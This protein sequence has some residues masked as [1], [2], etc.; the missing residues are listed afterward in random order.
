MNKPDYIICA[1]LHLVFTSNGVLALVKLAR[2][3]EKT[4]R[5]AFMCTYQ[6]V[7][8]VETAI[9]IDYDTYVPRNEAE[10]DFIGLIRRA[11][12]E[13][14][15]TLLKDFSQRHVDE[16]IIVYPEALLCNP[17]NGKRVVRY[18]LNRDGIVSG[19]KVNRP[20]RFHPCSLA[21]HASQS[22]SRLLFRSAQSAVS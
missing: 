18:F 12:S 3:I 14:G 16:C 21:G 2:S 8:G 11:T 1:P 17:L 15:I 6:H 20:Q 5:R 19:R 9:G 4:G 22:A 7:N 10:A 13:F